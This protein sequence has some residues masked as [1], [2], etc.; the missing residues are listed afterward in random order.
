MDAKRT[1]EEMCRANKKR[2]RRL[3]KSVKRFSR[4]R[5]MGI[6]QQKKD[7]RRHHTNLDTAKQDLS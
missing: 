5:E 6:E 4:Q 3:L 1:L 7:K 2:R